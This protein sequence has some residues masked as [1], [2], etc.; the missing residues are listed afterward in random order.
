[1]GGFEG[2]GL[3]PAGHLLEVDRLLPNGS[4]GQGLDGNGGQQDPHEI[5]QA[6]VEAQLSPSTACR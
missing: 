5:V 3:H 2:E 1:M 6:L 4:Y